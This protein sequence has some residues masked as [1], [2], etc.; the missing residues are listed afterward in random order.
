MPPAI[1]TS[2]PAAAMIS[3]AD[4][5]SR[6][7][8]RF[9]LVKNDSLVSERTTKR[10]VKG[11]RIPRLR[12]RAASA[13]ERSAAPGSRRGPA[14]SPASTSALMPSPGAGEADALAPASLRRAF[15]SCCRSGGLVGER[16]GEDRAL[17]D[18][19]ASQV[20][21]EPAAA[22]DQHAVREPDHL[23]ELRGD[24][25]HAEAVGRERG[26]EVVDRALR[27]DVDAAR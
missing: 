2:V 9:G 8:S 6:M 27:P 16:S 11:I 4:C 5:W 17:G 10:I 23:L 13:A 20:A 3:V 7:L 26:E 24:Q 19:F 1:T 21:H 15:V 12:R 25:Q 22:H 18:R 14:G